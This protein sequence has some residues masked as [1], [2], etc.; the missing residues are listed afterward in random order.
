LLY[1]CHRAKTHLQSNNNKYIHGAGTD[2]TGNVSSIVA[3][4]LV[5]GETACPESHS[6]TVTVVLSPVYTAV[7][8]QWLCMSQDVASRGNVISKLWIGKDRS[9]PN[10]MLQSN[11]V[12]EGLRKTTK[13]SL[14]ITDIPAEIWIRDLLNTKQ[15][16]YS[17]APDFYFE[18]V[19]KPKHP[20]VSPL[21]LSY[22]D[23]LCISTF[24]FAYW[25]LFLVP[26][27]LPTA[28][29][30]LTKLMSNV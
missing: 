14:T 29:D 10:L 22:Q 19:L 1:Y 30:C 17:P 26:F 24:P 21:K 18:H 13:S 27:D 8:W 25:Y 12:L 7:T 5:A 16:F 23:C 6:L 9:W 4:S 3:C 28:A 11:Q 15:E 20:E 2:H